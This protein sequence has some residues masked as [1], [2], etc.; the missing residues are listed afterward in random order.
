VKTFSPY[1]TEYTLKFLIGIAPCGRIIFV[2]VVYSGRASDKFIVNNSGI[3]NFLDPSDGVMVDK[4]F[5]I[6]DE[7]LRVKCELIRPPFMDKS[8]FSAKEGMENA[9]IAQLRVHVER[10][11]QRIKVFNVLRN[12]FPRCL[13]A[14][15]DKIL[16]VCSALVNLQ[17][18]IIANNDA[19]SV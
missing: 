1:Y 18:P 14:Q 2:S 15:A 11:I 4:G 9:D 19:F 5:L 6:D 16:T 8:K 17:T 7:I 3:L 12:E 13:H 10:A